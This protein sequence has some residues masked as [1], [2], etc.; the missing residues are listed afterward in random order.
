M[1]WVHEFRDNGATDIKIIDE[2]TC[3]YVAEIDLGAPFNA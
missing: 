3:Q 2:S 1:A